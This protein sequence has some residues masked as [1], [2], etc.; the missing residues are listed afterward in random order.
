MEDKS[1]EQTTSL[2]LSHFDTLLAST[3]SFLKVPST[4]PKLYLAL[5]ALEK[6]ILHGRKFPLPLSLIVIM[7]VV[8]LL[9]G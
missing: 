4:N 2:A 9:D 1:Q 3:D 6:E 5:K 8:A 7:V